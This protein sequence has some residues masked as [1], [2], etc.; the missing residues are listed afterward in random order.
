LFVVRQQNVYDYHRQSIYDVISHQ[1]IDW[2]RPGGGGSLPAGTPAAAAVNRDPAVGRDTLLDLLGDA[3]TSAPLI[4][5]IRFHSGHSL[6]GVGT[7][8]YEF[9]QP[10]RT[11]VYPR[12]AT[13]TP[14]DELLYVFGAPLAT[15]YQVDPFPATGYTRADRLLAETVVRYWSNFIRTGY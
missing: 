9:N 13:G 2:E 14:A 15:D 12:W 4:G 7:Y 11:D 6:P 5:T 1:Y 8:M 3:Q 10:A